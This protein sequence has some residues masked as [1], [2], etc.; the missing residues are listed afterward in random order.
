MVAWIFLQSIT[1]SHW[2]WHIF[3]IVYSVCTEHLFFFIFE[4][5]FLFFKQTNESFFVLS[6]I[7]VL[8]LLLQVWLM[9]KKNTMHNILMYF[10]ILWFLQ[11]NT[12]EGHSKS[13]KPQPERKAIVQHYYCGRTILMKLEILIQISVLNSVQVRP[14]KMGEVCELTNL[15]SEWGLE[16]FKDPC[17]FLSNNSDKN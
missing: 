10:F 15:K 8:S 16:L 17:T 5:V 14:I 6:Y 12:Y 3:Y 7:K 1:I 13:S 4:W 11:L 9:E 2:S